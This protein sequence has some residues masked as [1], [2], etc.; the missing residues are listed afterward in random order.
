MLLQ[1]NVNFEAVGISVE[2]EV[3]ALPDIELSFQ[4]FCHNEIFEYVADERGS[5]YA[6]GLSDS[7]QRCDEAGLGEVDFR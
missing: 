1:D 7:Q 5:A 3:G 2:E 6:R 4:Q